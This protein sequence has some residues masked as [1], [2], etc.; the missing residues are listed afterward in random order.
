MKET[1]GSGTNV[2]KGVEKFYNVVDKSGVLKN[3]EKN[4]NNNIE[5]VKTNL[6]KK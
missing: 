1:F 3:K 4:E 5:E 6:F 2:V